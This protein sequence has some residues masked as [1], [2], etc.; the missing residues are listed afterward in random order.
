[1]NVELPAPLR[2]ALLAAGRLYEVGGSVRDRYLGRPLYDRDYLVTG[3]PL[4][5]LERLLSRFG[6]A[7]LVGRSFGVVKFTFHPPDSERAVTVDIALPRRERSTG[8]GHRDFEVDF[9]PSL[10]VEDDLVR[11]DFTVNAMAI[12]LA[13]GDLI[14]PTGGRRDVEER[15]L[16]LIS[17][18]AIEEDP[19]RM[20]RA[21]GL[22]ARFGFSLDPPLEAALHSRAG[23]LREVAPERIAEEFT[24]IL[25]LAPRPSPALRLMETTGILDV[26][27]PELR[28]SAGCDQPG[29][30]HAYD[31]FEHSLRVVDAAPPRLA[32]RWAALLHDVEKPRTREIRE[33]KVTFYNHEVLGAETARKILSRFRYGHELAAHVEVLIER[34]LFNT[35]M[36]DRGLRRLVRAVGV[37]R[38]D[39]LLDLRR[40]DVEGQGMGA[41]TDDVDLFAARLA[42]LLAAQPP[43][44]RSELAVDGHALMETFGLPPGPKLGRTLDFLLERVLDEPEKND[45]ETLLKWAAEFLHRGVA[46][47]APA[48]L[49]A[50]A[51][52][53]G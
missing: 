38:M 44:T 40:A 33:D 19:L 3:I 2:S 6:Y 29:P 14:D 50:V 16:R 30:Y 23:L 7:D 51:L 43:F 18:S 26:L 22:V 39:D 53:G 12:D 25:T 49:Y 15:R 28:D 5:D 13:T 36:G 52:L 35:D 8:P 27:I 21:L 45:R 20:L 37:D 11:R 46:L 10:P 41:P 1:M 24:K 4:P 48:L 47:A 31:V 17:P 9:D 34:H 42:E 32:L